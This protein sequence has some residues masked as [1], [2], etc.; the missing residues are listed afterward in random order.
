VSSYYYIDCRVIACIYDHIY[1]GIR[2]YIV[3]GHICIRTHIYQHRRVIACILKKRLLL[4]IHSI[5]THIAAQH[6]PK[7]LL[8]AIGIDCQVIA[9][10]YIV[11]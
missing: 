1:S 2:T 8:E 10:M 11:V 7:I 6:P 3:S 5:R 4:L 9:G